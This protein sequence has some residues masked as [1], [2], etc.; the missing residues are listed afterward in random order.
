MIK[1]AVNWLQITKRVCGHVACLYLNQDGF[2]YEENSVCCAVD[3]SQ[4]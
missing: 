3:G 4:F 2:Y 1:R